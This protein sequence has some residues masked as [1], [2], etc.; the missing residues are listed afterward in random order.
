MN[1]KYTIR[2][3]FANVKINVNMQIIHKLNISISFV[4]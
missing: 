1:I 4:L 3:F 2:E